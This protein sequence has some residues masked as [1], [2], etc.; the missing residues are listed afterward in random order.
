MRRDRTKTAPETTDEHSTVDETDA[1]HGGVEGHAMEHA[2]SPR[3]AATAFG[4]SPT[5]VQL[6]VSR[7]ELVGRVT[8]DGRLL[9]VE[10]EYGCMLAEPPRPNRCSRS[11]SLPTSED[12]LRPICGDWVTIEPHS[13]SDPHQRR[14]RIRRVISRQ[15]FVVRS[16]EGQP[17]VRPMVA[18]IDE[19]W[20]VCGLD[21]DPTLRNLLRYR[22]ILRSAGVAIVVVLNKI[23]LIEN[24]AEVQTMALS[25]ADGAEVV[26]LSALTGSGLKSLE[27]RLV[28]G[29]TIALLGASGAGKSTLVNALLETS[30]ARTGRV[31]DAD[32]RGRHTSTGS[33]LRVTK[34]G[35]LIIDT[36]GSRELGVC[37]SEAG[38]AQVFDSI[39]QYAQSCRFGDC[40]HEAEPGCAVRVALE[41][42]LIA[43]ERFLKYLELRRET[44][45]KSRQRRVRR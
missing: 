45:R 35:A 9:R 2:G 20:I 27:R 31:G 21:R 4:G 22:T 39:E 43:P 34:Q 40:R 26:T 24:V 16:H 13:S 29:R 7:G 17:G 42:G 18:N 25:Q 8:E 38:Q 1:S 28:P 33:C 41:D 30:A 5:S 32:A 3:S 36:P 15:N 12:E 6:D 11:R 44:E 37:G 10:T 19:G 23:E 14:G